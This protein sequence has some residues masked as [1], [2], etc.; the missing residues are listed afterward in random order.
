MD[1]STFLFLRKALMWFQWLGFVPF[2]FLLIFL[3]A[4]FSGAEIAFFSANRYRLKIASERHRSAAVVLSLLSRSDELLSTLLVCNNAVNVLLATLV[5]Y[6]LDHIYGPAGVAMGGVA[7]TLLLILFGEIVPKSIATR[8]PETFSRI[9]AYPLWFITYAILPLVRLIS[10]ISKG[11]LWMLRIRHSQNEMGLDVE[12]I[13]SV[14][15]GAHRMTPTHKRVML[16]VLSLQEKEVVDLIS[17]AQ[18]IDFINL[19]DTD[20]QIV[21]LIETTPHS[22]LP[23]SSD[24]MFTQI[25][26]Y[27]RTS[28]AARVIVAGKLDRTAL[29]CDLDDAFFVPQQMTA[30]TFLS[31]LANRQAKMA[32]VVDEMGTLLGL[33]TYLNVMNDITNSLQIGKESPIGHQ[34]SRLVYLLY[35]R[36]S[37]SDIGAQFSL[38]LR[39]LDSGTKLLSGFILE[40]IETLPEGPFSL[41]L[42]QPPC[43]ID[44][45]SLRERMIDRVRLTLL[46]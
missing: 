8:H 12:E 41:R 27:F 3:S 46:S 13:R 4:F 6:I 40:H 33:L 30:L 39:A 26:G 34:E 19:S 38:N 35:G 5:S 42:N 25:H 2:V 22:L 18:S 21:A 37:L 11:I 7:T 36:A 17:P 1:F 31:T 15:H 32:L 16:S 20:E 44:V 29:L 9:V 24:D 45:L 43:Q 23:V 10:L 28:C 14:V